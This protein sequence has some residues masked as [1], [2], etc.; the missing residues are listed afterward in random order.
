MVD[1]KALRC[2]VAC[3]LAAVALLIPSGC[4]VVKMDS[5]PSWL[6]GS[7]GTTMTPQPASSRTTTSTDFIA[8]FVKGSRLTIAPRGSSP[9]RVSPDEAMRILLAGPTSAE[10]KSG[11]RSEI[12]AGTKVNALDVDFYRTARLDLSAEFA[13]GV[14]GKPGAPR[15]AQIVY[16]LTQLGGITAVQITI[17]GRKVQQMGSDRLDLMQ[18]KTR[19]DFPTPMTP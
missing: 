1:R 15:V 7:S 8:Y 9:A 6:S 19:A 17:D 18:P 5:P 11:M 3:L 16:T 13:S 14:N 2:V 4:T 12:P 10:R